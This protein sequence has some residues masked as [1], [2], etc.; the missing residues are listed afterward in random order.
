MELK[1]YYKIGANRVELRLKPCA[2]ITSDCDGGLANWERNTIDLGNDMPEDRQATA[3]LH[4]VL[5]MMNIYLTEEQAT[6]I[7]EGLTQIIRDN[8]INFLK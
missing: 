3:F 6:Y 8:K 4:E 7:S 1:K 5:H 2:D